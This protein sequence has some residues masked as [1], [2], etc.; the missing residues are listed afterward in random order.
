MQGENP[1]IFISVRESKVSFHRQ[2][3]DSL[4]Y[5]HR[6]YSLHSP[7]LSAATVTLFSSSG[8]RLHYGT[9]TPPASQQM[10][11]LYIAVSAQPRRRIPFKRLR[12]CHS[13]S[14]SSSCPTLVAQS[15]A[16]LP[17]CLTAGQIY[18]QHAAVCVIGAQGNISSQGATWC[19]FSEEFLNIKVYR[20]KHIM[21]R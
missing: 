11:C 12:G 14:R 21:A 17:A 1:A 10:L 6:A 5:R 2:P 9:N 8:G 7:P 13:D 3:T 16:R 15:V 19:L 4:R 18:I 20:L